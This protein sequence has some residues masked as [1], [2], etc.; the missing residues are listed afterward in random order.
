MV[1]F[2][3]KVLVWLAAFGVAFGLFVVFLLVLIAGLGAAFS[4]KPVAVKEGSVLVLNLDMSIPDSPEADDPMAKVQGLLGGTVTKQLPLLRL[5]RGLERAAEDPRI[6]GVLVRG[7]LK[8][9]GYGTSTVAL[10]DVRAA[11]GRLRDAGK[12]VY[13]YVDVDGAADF[14]IKSAA[15]TVLMHPLGELRFLGIG[16]DQMHFGDFLRRFGVDPVA[17]HREEY[18]TVWEMVGSGSMSDESR[19]QYAEII[20][21]IWQFYV[22]GIAGARGIAEK[23]VRRMAD[24]TGILTATELLEGGWIDGEAHVDELLEKLIEFAGFDAEA[25]SF[26]QISISDYL[27]A[28]PAPGKREKRSA[29]TVAVIYA[30]GVIVDGRGGPGQAGG[31]RIA[32]LIRDARRDDS[33]K[34]VVLRVNSPGGGMHGSEKI[35]REVERTN[36]EK[37][38]VVSLGGYATSGGYWISARADTIFAADTTVTGSIGVAFLMPVIEELLETLDIRTERV[39]TGPLSAAFSTTRAKTE[40]EMALLNRWV[41]R[42]YDQFVTLVAEGR[43]MDAAAARD[44]AK[45][46]VW[47]GDAA[48]ARGLVDRAGSL[49]DAVAFAADRAGIGDDYVIEEHPGRRTFEDIVADLLSPGAFWN[50]RF[51]AGRD[52][53]SREL[54][55]FEAQLEFFRQLDDPRGLFALD[56]RFVR[57]D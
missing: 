38:V 23:D 35:A 10:Q 56:P 28:P 53:L 45:G 8:S 17:I 34:A 30:E 4:A 9:E 36:R 41:D 21:A 31:D 47:M 44:V 26:T 15:D 20:D 54:R 19:E 49:Q 7:N 43:G 51:L 12:P 33:V 18:K 25:E 42:A 14:Y 3:R 6:K 50:G 27:D 39:T 5:V 24:E 16:L 22:G 32:R 13:A 29:N 48:L 11:L 55:A 2:F 37:P 52:P 1:S 40:A 46:R 57:V